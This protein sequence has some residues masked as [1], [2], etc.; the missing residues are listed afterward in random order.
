MFTVWNVGGQ[1]KLRPLWR[2]Y[3]NNTDGLMVPHRRRQET[4]YAESIGKT[5]P[6]NMYRTLVKANPILL[7]LIT[8][9][10]LHLNL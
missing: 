10:P 5:N 7:L 9:V 4:L 8:R 3:F 1:E 2:H 6:S